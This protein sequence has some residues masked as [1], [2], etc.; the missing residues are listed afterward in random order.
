M[1]LNGFYDSKV[2]NVDAKTNEFT[3]TTT[4]KKKKT[5]MNRIEH[6]DIDIGKSNGQKGSITRFIA[7]TH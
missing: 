4:R 5:E 3:T 1:H 7:H 2:N 6:H